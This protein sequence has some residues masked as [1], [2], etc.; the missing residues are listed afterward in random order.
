MPHGVHPLRSPKPDGRWTVRPYTP[1]PWNILPAET[2][3]S[4]AAFQAYLNLGLGRS[5]AAAWRSYKNRPDAI[6]ALTPG[7]FM[8]WAHKFNWHE[9]AKAW[10]EHAI[11]LAQDTQN[12][13]MQ[14]EVG[15]LAKRRISAFKLMLGIGTQVMA[16]AAKDLV[17]LSPDEARR[18]LPLAMQLAQVAAMGIRAEFAVNPRVAIGPG[19][20]FAGVSVNVSPKGDVNVTA[21]V[22]DVAKI[23]EDHGEP[24]NPLAPEPG[25]ASP[26]QGDPIEL[27][28]TVHSQN[29]KSPAV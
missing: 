19:M 3:R 9:R 26:L 11:R 13:E 27:L 10:D 28:P 7:Y 1:Q 6:G 22:G 18:M 15:D 24:F 16:V 17:N 20:P 2:P 8:K 29:G 5:I 21:L 25:Q 4:F 14:K 12:A 23:L